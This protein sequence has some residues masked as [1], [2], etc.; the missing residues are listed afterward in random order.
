M[1]MS[2]VFS[3]GQI[4]AESV[5]RIAFYKFYFVS[6]DQIL[7]I[8]HFIWALKGSHKIFVMLVVCKSFFRESVIFFC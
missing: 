8:L 5:I 6:R 3:A 4:K 1:L 7:R 2:F